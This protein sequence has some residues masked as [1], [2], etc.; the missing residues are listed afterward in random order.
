MITRDYMIENDENMDWC[1][2]FRLVEKDVFWTSCEGVV[3]SVKIGGD[4]FTSVT[5]NVLHK[6]AAVVNPEY[7]LYE[8]NGC[9]INDHLYRSEAKVKE[10]PCNQCPWFYGCEAMDSE[11]E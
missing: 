8:K 2:P 5:D 11:E 1:K 6:L 3:S 9:S 7:N 10:L 4:E